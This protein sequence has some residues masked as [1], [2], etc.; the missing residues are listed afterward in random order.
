M[1]HLVATRTS[2]PHRNLAQAVLLRAVRQ[3]LSQTRLYLTNPHRVSY[4]V[5]DACTKA[6]YM[7]VASVLTILPS[8]SLTES[9][10]RG[11]LSECFKTNAVDTKKVPTPP[12][13]HPSDNARR[14]K[15]SAQD[16]D[17]S[18]VKPKKTP[19]ADEDCFQCRRRATTVCGPVISQG[20]LDLTAALVVLA[21]YTFMQFL[22]KPTYQMHIRYAAHE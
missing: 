2:S 15:G 14:D 6:E 22:R 10:P 7:F 20:D 11:L 13:A 17:V 4:T 12:R 9:R 19:P 21:H 5:F 8:P 1:R 3:V 16:S 18:K